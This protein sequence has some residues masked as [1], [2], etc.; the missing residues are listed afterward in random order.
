HGAA[1]RG[2]GRSGQAS[3]GYDWGLWQRRRVTPRQIEE[4]PGPRRRHATLFFA[5]FRFIQSKAHHLAA[6]VS[7]IAA[8]KRQQAEKVPVAR[9]ALICFGE[10]IAE[11]GPAAR[12]QVH[13]QKRRFAHHVATPEAV[14]E[15]DA[16]ENA[17]VSVLHTDAFASHVAVP[18]DDHRP[19][20]LARA[21]VEEI[22]FCLD[23]A[24]HPR[25]YRVISLRADRTPDE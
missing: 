10:E 24:I 17:D 22:G 11:V 6:H 19:R 25:A 21:T 12:V 16:V 15:F 2:S 1:N 18:V 14:I 8:V 4:A 3:D 5:E 23:L 9:P 13:R 7:S 20:A